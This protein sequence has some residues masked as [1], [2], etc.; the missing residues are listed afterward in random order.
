MPV[1][2]VALVAVKTAPNTLEAAP[3]SVKSEVP[4]VKTVY[5]D[6]ITKALAAIGVCKDGKTTLKVQLPCVAEAIV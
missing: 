5:L 3:A 4:K 2:K 6:P 1:P